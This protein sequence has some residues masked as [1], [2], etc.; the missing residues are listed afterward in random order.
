MPLPISRSAASN[1]V[2]Q[3]PGTPRPLAPVTVPEMVPVPRTVT[4]T[5]V[6]TEPAVRESAVAVACDEALGYQT[7]G[8][9]TPLQSMKV[10]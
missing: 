1:T 2:A 8:R 6:C 4:S 7:C 5:P 3:T 10:R 9:P